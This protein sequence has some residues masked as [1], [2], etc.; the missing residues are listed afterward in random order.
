M[1]RTATSRL[2]SKTEAAQ[3]AAALLDQFGTTVKPGE[4]E[5]L[6]IPT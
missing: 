4:R 5:I 6:D 2:P 1:M 3:L